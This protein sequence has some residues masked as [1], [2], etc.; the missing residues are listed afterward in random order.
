MRRSDEGQSTVELALVLPLVVVMLVAGVYCGRLVTAYIMVT[1]AAREGV[2]AAA[3]DGDPRAAEVAARAAGGLDED[4]LRVE[5]GTRGEPG[6]KVTVTI[7]YRFANRLPLLRHLVGG[8]DLRA[9]A[10]MRVE[11]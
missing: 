1:H 4:Q 6:S 11:R 7:R 3:V 10:T 2:R 5:T 8:V 9:D